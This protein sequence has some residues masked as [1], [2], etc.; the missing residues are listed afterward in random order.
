MIRSDLMMSL[1]AES[2][3]EKRLKRL[4]AMI[5]DPRSAVNLESLL[6]SCREC[7]TRAMQ[8][9]SCCFRFTEKQTKPLLCNIVTEARRVCVQCVFSWLK[10]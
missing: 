7:F 5:R 8:L 4:E 3:M 10:W 9:F 1:G 6:V 2:R